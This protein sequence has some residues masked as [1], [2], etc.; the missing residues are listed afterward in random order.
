MQNP[1]TLTPLDTQETGRRQTKIKHKTT[2]KTNNMSNTDPTKSRVNPCA[3]QGWTVPASNKKTTSMLS[4]LSL[5]YC[6]FKCVLSLWFLFQCRLFIISFNFHT[7][8]SNSNSNV[9]VIF[10][11]KLNIFVHL[12]WAGFEI[13]TI[14]VI[15]TDCIRSYKSNYHTITTIPNVYKIAIICSL[16]ILRMSIN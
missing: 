10:P 1:E 11:T 5:Q 16:K 6:Y 15:C 3:R 7:L 2:K 12:S 13:T 14:V 4:T 9:I 8:S